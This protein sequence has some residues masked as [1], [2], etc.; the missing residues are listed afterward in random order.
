MQVTPDILVATMREMA[1]AR[2]GGL[3]RATELAAL[4]EAR[5]I[6]CGPPSNWYLHKADRA[7]A[8]NASRLL[9]FKRTPAQNAAVYLAIRGDAPVPPAPHD[10]H[11][12]RVEA[13]RLG[14]V[15][16]VWGGNGWT[17]EPAPARP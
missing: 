14:W 5:G 10:D 12:A 1:A 8:A 9:R 17:V 15:E 7:E 2:A 16:C 11:P 4:C 3:V 6:L 13:R